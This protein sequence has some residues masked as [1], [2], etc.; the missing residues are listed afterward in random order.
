MT[1]R[2]ASLTRSQKVAVPD[3]GSVAAFLRETREDLESGFPAWFMP[4]F[5]KISGIT[6]A[7]VVVA[8]VLTSGELGPILD[9]TTWNFWFRWVGPSLLTV[10]TLLL[11]Y[12]RAQR[13][14]KGGA[15]AISEEI[16]KKW[17]EMTGEGWLKRVAR[18]GA[19]MAGWVGVP[20]GLVLAAAFPV[21]EAT[22]WTRIGMLLGF[23]GL[24]ALWTFPM[25]LGI[26]W[27]SM[28]HHRQFLHFRLI[29]VEAPPETPDM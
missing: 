2:S 29:P 25:A 18:S 22:I 24:T 9:P 17:E 26:R 7:A 3:E 1:P 20:I 15:K 10:P 27:V 11:E 21:P 6:T 12:R 4:R 14:V 16:R 5:L 8:P 13:R 28:R 23:I 19:R